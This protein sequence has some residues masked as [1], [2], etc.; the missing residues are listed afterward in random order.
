[1]AVLMLHH[2]SVVVADLPKALSFYRDL[3][4][5]EQ[6]FSRDKDFPGAW[7]KIGEHQQIHLLRVQNCDPT[8]NRPP[9]VGRDRHIAL[10]V[11]DLNDFEA[12]LTAAGI[13]TRRSRS[14]RQ[15]LFCRDP[16]GNG[17][18]L[19]EAFSTG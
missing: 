3:L 8:E 11:D 6:E 16:D 7:L 10:W 19:V 2:A 17:I 12:R 9:Y 1:M 14:G 18:E 15:A 13:P 4:G 5:L